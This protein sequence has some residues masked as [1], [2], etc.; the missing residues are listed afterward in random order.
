MLDRCDLTE[1]FFLNLNISKRYSQQVKLNNQ[2]DRENKLF[3]QI[4]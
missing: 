1:L 4:I 3:I 2:T